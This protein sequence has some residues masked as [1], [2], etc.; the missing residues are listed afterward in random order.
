MNYVVALLFTESRREMVLIRKE[1]SPV[2]EHV[3]KLNGPGG[4]MEPGET[5][6]MAV[7]REVWEETGVDMPADS[8]EDV[9]T[10]SGPDWVVHFLT[11]T[12]SWASQARTR[13]KEEVVRLPTSFVVSL[14]SDVVPNIRWLTHMV[15][16]PNGP[17]GNLYNVKDYAP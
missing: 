15:L 8:Y 10:L 12:T 6:K 2:P 4:K 3:G 9:C 5:P 14:N 7:A 13:E 1:K 17:R 16:D 11:L